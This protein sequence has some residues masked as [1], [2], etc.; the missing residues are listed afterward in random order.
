V[1]FSKIEAPMR[2]LTLAPVGIRPDAQKVGI[3][4]A[5]IRKGLERAQIEGWGAVFVLG[6]PAYYGRF[7]FQADTAEL[8]ASPYHGP[9]FMGLL[10][11][12]GAPKSGQ[13]DFPAAFDQ[14]IR[15]HAARQQATKT[16][17]TS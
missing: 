12:E 13:L 3:G 10:C 15:E 11:D 8:Y 7:G 9:D 1:L 14:D 6:S 16:P 2:A 17:R 5:M 4:S